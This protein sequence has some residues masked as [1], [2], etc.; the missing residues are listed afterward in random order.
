MVNLLQDNPMLKIKK[1]KK[2]WLKERTLNA[3]FNSMK[4][5]LTS[6]KNASSEFFQSKK[7]Q[8]KSA[9]GFLNLSYKSKRV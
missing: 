8:L 4:N 6:S 9:E 7:K 2:A 1:L 5:F 3:S